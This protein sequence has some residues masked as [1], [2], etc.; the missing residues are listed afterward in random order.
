MVLMDVTRNVILANSKCP[1]NVTLTHA[2]RR[3]NVTLTPV[4]VR[5]AVTLVVR[6]VT[7]TSGRGIVPDV[8]GKSCMDVSGQVLAS[9]S[10]NAA[11]RRHGDV[12]LRRRLDKLGFITG[13]RFALGQGRPLTP[14]HGPGISAPTGARRAL[15]PTPLTTAPETASGP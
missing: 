4:H 9:V 6:N 2:E 14:K 11:G 12:R 8:M 7:L 13:L 1:P 5:S 10:R 15:A 3:L